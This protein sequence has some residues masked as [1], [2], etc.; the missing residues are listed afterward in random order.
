MDDLYLIST[1]TCPC[2][3]GRTHR[4]IIIADN[5]MADRDAETIWEDNLLRNPRT[6][7][8]IQHTALR[9]DVEAVLG[10]ALK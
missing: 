1:W 6:S 4:I 7:N 5:D 10:A 2:A 9:S 8:I 3:C